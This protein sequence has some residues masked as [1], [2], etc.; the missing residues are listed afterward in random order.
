MLTTPPEIARLR[1]H[2]QLISHS[3]ART[4][5]EVV[6]WLG[7]VQAQD[8]AGAKWSLALRLPGATE[9]TIDQAIRD[10]TIVRTWPMRGTLHFV[11]AADVRWLLPLLAPRIVA[12]TA[13]RY[14]QLEL[15][16]ATFA[17]SAEVLGRALQGQRRLARPEVY[18]LLEANGISPAGQRGIHII[19]YLAQ[20]GLLC[21]GPREGAQPSFALLDEWVPPTAPL[22]REEALAK[23]AQRYFTSH[24]PAT[25]PDFVWW[26]GLPVGD[27]RLA[28]QLAQSALTSVTI[29]GN[30]YWLADTLPPQLPP[31]QA[32]LLPGFDE[33]M[34]GYTDRSAALAPQHRPLLNPTNGGILSATMVLDG[35][36]VGTWR[37]TLRKKGVTVEL[38]P[39]EPL[40]AGQRELLEPA[41]ARYA[42][43]LGRPVV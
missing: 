27:A 37:R 30:T 5:A 40:T 36:V 43:Y 29:E 10:K 35:Q 32:Y 13:G 28:L 9:A 31:P 4:P 25:L 11:A 3:P 14:R 19:G 38:S 23:L 12:R 17:R 26:T 41:L 6:A 20:T 1:L 15:D 2:N 39:F 21:E 7:A 42:A 22:A 16:E 18:A 24:G 33:L 34:L 8:F